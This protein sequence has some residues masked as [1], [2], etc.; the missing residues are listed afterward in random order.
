MSNLTESVLDL[1]GRERD[2]FV[3]KSLGI[4]LGVTAA[5]YLLVNWYWLQYLLSWAAYG[6]LWLFNFDVSWIMFDY[7]AAGEEESVGMFEGLMEAYRTFEAGTPVL[8]WHVGT[9]PAVRAHYV[10]RAA[11]HF[12]IVKACTA[13]QAGALM[14][15][16]VM[17]TPAERNKKIKA[18]SWMFIGLFIGNALRIALIIATT[19]LFVDEFGMTYAAGWMWAHDVSGKMISFIGT[20]VF[21][22]IIEKQ[23]VRVLDTITVWM[24]TLLNKVGL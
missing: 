8:N 18:I 16:L 6:L 9:A 7:A 24:D 4:T 23:G 19:V 22:V 10:T 3:L 14:I 12:T 2:K 20:I 21:T 13:M 11:T 17:A 5:L 1:K 15:G